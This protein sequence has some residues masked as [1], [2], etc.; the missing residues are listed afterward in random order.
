MLNKLLIGLLFSIGLLPGWVHADGKVMPPRDYQGSLEERAQEAI[1]IFHGSKSGEQAVQ[2]MIL[3]I[4]VEGDTQEF[5]WIIPLPNEPKVA[6]ED[7]KLFQELFNYVEYQR[8]RSRRKVV[9]DDLDSPRSAG[10][11]DNKVE[12]LKRE[13]VGEFDITTV[14]ETAEG[15]L[16]PWLEKEG[17][18]TLDNA[19]DVLEFYRNKDYVYVCIKVSAEA[20]ASE[21]SIESHPLRFTFNTGGNDGIFFPMKLTGL[22]SMN[23]DVNLYVFYDAWL[24]DNKNE[25]GY[26]NRGMQ[27]KYRDWDTAKCKKNAGKNYSVPEEDPLLRNAAHKIPTVKKLFQKLHPG[28]RYYLT[29]L[30]A[31]N[32][33]P[34][35]VRHWSDDLWMYPNYINRDF[36]PLDARGP[37]WTPPE[38]GAE[39]RK[40]LFGRLVSSRLMIGVIVGLIALFALAVLVFRA[41][42]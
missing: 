23:F 21:R 36:V 20:L 38:N 11:S 18:Q 6:K 35:D 26:R 34:E 30:Y 22:Q 28:K 7:P 13:T 25:Y 5:A 29:N 4:E 19:D 8:R 40:G 41:G 32:L 14:R 33:N 37:D 39:D 2:D 15:G 42:D 1:I 10:E 27:L 16:N 3:K 17:Y 31:R 9:K 24:N 12:V